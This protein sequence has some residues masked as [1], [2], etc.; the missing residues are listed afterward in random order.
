[1]NYDIK[2]HILDNGLVLTLKDKSKILSGDLWF[3]RLEITTTCYLENS[4]E[5]L[6]RYFGEKITRTK[7]IERP[8]VHESVLDETKKALTESYLGSTLHYMQ[9]PKFLK[10]FKEKE[11]RDYLEKIEKEQRLREAGVIP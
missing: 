2:E 1:M 10:R 11:L 4:D 7:L 5:E 3:V 9:T 6:R 8:A